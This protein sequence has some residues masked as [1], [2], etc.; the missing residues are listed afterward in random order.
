MA[1]AKID[2]GQL[3][4]VGLKRKVN[5]DSLGVHVPAAATPEQEY[6]M[7]FLVADG[8]G[9]MGK[10]EVASQT[11]VRVITERYY[12]PSNE[13]PDLRR[14]FEDALQAANIAV[15]ETA[16]ELGL[17]RIG[18][19][20]VG[21]VLTPTGEAIVTNIGDSRGYRIRG[22]S[23]ERITEDDSAELSSG[24]AVDE[25]YDKRNSKITTYIGQPKPL[26]LHTR[27][28]DARN[29]DTYVLCT[30]GV[31]SLVENSEIFSI[32]DGTPAQRATQQLID[33]AKKRGAPDNA[34]AIVV[35]LGSPPRRGLPILPIVLGILVLAAAILAGLFASGTLQLPTQSQAT[36]IAAAVTEEI[37]E[38]PTAANTETATP[39]DTVTATETSTQTATNTPTVT[40][41]DTKTSTPTATPTATATATDT[42]TSTPTATNTPTE[43]ATPTNTPTATP[44]ETETQAVV[45][46]IANASATAEQ[47]AIDASA[48]AAKETEEFFE[49]ETATHLPPTVT[50]DPNVISPTPSTTPTETQ[51]PTPIPPTPVP[52]LSPEEVLTIAQEDGIA[53]GQVTILYRIA[54]N[55]TEWRITELAELP[56][57][58]TAQI[59]SSVRRTSPDLPGEVLRKVEAM[60]EDGS[61]QVGW[62]TESALETGETLAVT[63]TITQRSGS[64]MRTTDHP[65]APLVRSVPEG[66][67]L[68]ILSRSEDG[69]YEVE[70]DGHTGWV[71]GDVVTVTGNIDNVPFGTPPRYVSP[72]PSL[73]A[74]PDQITAT[75]E[76]TEEASPDGE[77][78]NQG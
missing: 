45:L 19:T 56:P 72:T 63:L 9:G 37:T 3:S 20:I 10:G 26:Q 17:K 7:L 58:T 16:P 15:R 29:G 74:T 24:L 22:N 25:V 42:E 4:D 62:M 51:T 28:L 14:R 71:S 48:T 49:T 64:A 31:W 66:T 12:D 50:L 57:D 36:V 60:L 2:I 59:I 35:R 33:L 52:T 27:L 67:M 46:E 43:S 18:T 30:D 61:I 13:E 65:D 54:G 6:G 11:A 73:S 34:T 23:I 75:P 76:A 40:A 53:L 8:I 55:P 41:T 39:T 68:E 47:V 77:S 32:V 69:W 1:A 44:N 78:A 5:E 70:Y 21:M 38:E